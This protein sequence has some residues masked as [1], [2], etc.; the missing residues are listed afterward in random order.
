MY[1]V[2]VVTGDELRRAPRARRNTDN[3]LR[4]PSDIIND[5]NGEFPGP[6]DADNPMDLYTTAVWTNPD[7][8]PLMF[9]V[10]NGSITTGPD[11]T[12]YV[13]AELDEGTEYGV[14]DYIRLESDDGVVS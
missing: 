1:A 7:D 3:P 12:V 11:G 10:G 6:Y 8:V 4:S 5:N 14:F 13:N 2:I 9:V